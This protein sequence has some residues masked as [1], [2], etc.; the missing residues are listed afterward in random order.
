MPD[1]ILRQIARQAVGLPEPKS[2][3]W[4]TPE[5]ISQAEEHLQKHAGLSPVG[6]Q[7]LVA[8]WSNVE[9]QGGPGA[10]N[11]SSKAFGIAQWLGSRKK[12]VPS[13]F[14]GQL[15]HAVRELNSYE[16]K[17]AAR[18]RNAQ[19]PEEAA[20]GAAMFERAEGYNP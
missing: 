13:D 17:A 19:T 9:A 20:I 11:P 3:S 8:R 10:V 1:D 7:G 6:A 18:L 5:R 12:G 2:G 4:W 15:N 16:G 14:E